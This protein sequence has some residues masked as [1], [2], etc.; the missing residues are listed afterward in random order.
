MPLFKKKQQPEKKQDYTNWDKDL[1]FLNLILS[2][3]KGITKEFLINTYS[4]Q[5]SDKDYLTDEEIN[6]IVQNIVSEVLEQIGENYQNFLIE[7]YFGTQK[8]LISFITE[9]VY[10]DLISDS[11]NRNTL[12][13]KS[14]MYGKLVNTLGKL[15]K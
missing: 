6:P 10:V 9:D 15:N 5:K 2:R 1:G 3:K 14:G 12:K 11:I 7:K 13:I 4:L 8:S